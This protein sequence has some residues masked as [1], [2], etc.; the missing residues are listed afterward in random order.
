LLKRYKTSYI[1]YL[2]RTIDHEPVRSYNFRGSAQANPTRIVVAKSIKRFLV[3]AES[4]QGRR[5]AGWRHFTAYL[6]K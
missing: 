5:D 3:T 2:Q 1:S 6:R 4:R